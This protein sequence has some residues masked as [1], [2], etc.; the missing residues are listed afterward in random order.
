MKNLKTKISRIAKDFAIIRVDTGL[1]YNLSNYFGHPVYKDYVIRFLGIPVFKRGGYID[2]KIVN[3]PNQ[4]NDFHP[5][6]PN[7]LSTEI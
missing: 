7:K 6:L 5:D 4:V 3:T 1:R 2:G